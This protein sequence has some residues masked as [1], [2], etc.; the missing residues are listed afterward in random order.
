MYAFKFRKSMMFGLILDLRALDHPDARGHAIAYDTKGQRLVFV[1]TRPTGALCEKVSLIHS[2]EPD[3]VICCHPHQT[4]RLYP[5][6]PILGDW[7]SRTHVHGT[8][9]DCVLHIE[10]SKQ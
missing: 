5:N 10:E 6:L 1:H 2:L 8:D 9:I 4:K 3:V 7:L